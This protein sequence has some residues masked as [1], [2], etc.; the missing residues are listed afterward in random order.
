MQDAWDRLHDV[1]G[2]LSE[3]LAGSEKQLFRDSLVN[4]AVDLCELL[5]KL[6]VTNDSKLETCRKKLESAL[7]GV[8]AEDLRKDDDLRLDVKAKVDSILSMF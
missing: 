1:L 2:K 6:N 8:G 4:N 7:V 3:K 5:S